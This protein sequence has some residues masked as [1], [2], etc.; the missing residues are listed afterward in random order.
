MECDRKDAE[1]ARLEA[2][3]LQRDK[4]NSLL[5]SA[6]QNEVGKNDPDAD[7]EHDLV[8]TNAALGLVSKYNWLASRDARKREEI[9]RYL[10]TGNN[11]DVDEYLI[12]SNGG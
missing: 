2:A 11:S 7:Y 12:L 10:R 5:V 3:L 9:E 1:I 4:D 6:V 8:L